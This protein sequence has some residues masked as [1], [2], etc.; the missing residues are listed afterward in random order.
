MNTDDVYEYVEKRNNKDVNFKSNIAQLYKNNAKWIVPFYDVLVKSIF[1]WLI[2]KGNKKYFFLGTRFANLITALP[3]NEICIIGGPKQLLFCLKNN[4]SY[5]PNGTFWNVLSIG[6]ERDIHAQLTML[7][8]KMKHN[9]MKVIDRSAQPL[10][11]VENDS[12]P[13]QRV[14]CNIASAVNIKTVC[15]Q[16]GLFQSKT[17]A[18]TIDGWIC[19]YFVCYDNNQKNVVTGLGL[20]STKVVIGGFYEPIKK[21]T[22]IEYS[23][24]IRVCFLGQPWFKYGEKY[25]QKYLAIIELLSSQLSKD[26]ILYNFKAH[27]WETDAPYLQ[28]MKNIYHGNM[29]DAI[30]DHD[31]FLSLTSTA[32]LE[33]T[34]SG[35]VSI[36]IYDPQFNCDNFEMLGYAYTIQSE[37]LEKLLLPTINNPPFS[38]EMPGFDNLVYQIEE[39][40]KVNM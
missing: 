16:H 23:N 26:A 25:K 30:R 39:L 34:M 8:S 15:I 12:L 20:D 35:K 18:E 31:V 37:D 24:P 14:F 33:V 2:P 40:S 28:N 22:N 29:E 11:I 32:L 21:I 17:D 13:L 9:F 19:D 36:Q 38:L 5:L 1:F 4:I 7:S 10:I 3:K 27:P 6:F